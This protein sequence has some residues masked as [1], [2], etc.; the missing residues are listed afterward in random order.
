MILAVGKYGSH[1]LNQEALNY[2]PGEAEDWKTCFKP[3]E[4]KYNYVM[5]DVRIQDYNKIWN[6][7]WDANIKAEMKS[8][9]IVEESRTRM[10]SDH[11]SAGLLLKELTWLGEFKTLSF[12]EISLMSLKL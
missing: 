7:M 8:I 4:N 2:Y 3:T 11:P 1:E 5:I 9:T 12:I 6:D 10:I